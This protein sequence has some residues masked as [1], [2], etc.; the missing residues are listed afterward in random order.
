[1]PLSLLA[2]ILYVIAVVALILL[3]D[4]LCCLER[5]KGMFAAL[6]RRFY[7]YSND[8]TLPTD[9]VEESQRLVL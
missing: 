3:I 6:Y 8:Q 4:L 5:G 9:Y 2:I 1:M 7:R